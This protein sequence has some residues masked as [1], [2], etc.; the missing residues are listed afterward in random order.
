MRLASAFSRAAAALALAGS[1]APAVTLYVPGDFPAIQPALNAAAQGDTVL[2]AAGTYTGSGNTDLQIA[3]SLVLRGADGSAETLI[4]CAG[5]GRG[6]SVLPGVAAVIEGFAITGANT[7]GD[8]A[9]IRV[10]AAQARVAD[11]E[12][13]ANQTTGS[14]ARG[15]A[16]HVESGALVVDNCFI[17]DNSATANTSYGG[18]ISARKSDLTCIDTELRANQADDGG[19]IHV[20]GDYSN[21][22]LIALTRCTLAGNI[23]GSLGGGWYCSYADVVVEES[24]VEN[25]Y[26]DWTGSGM[27]L[28]SLG[29]FSL[30]NSFIDRNLSGY[31]GGGVYLSGAELAVIENSAMT[32]NAGFNG[33]GLYLSQADSLLVSNCVVLGNSA[34]SLYGAGGISIFFESSGTIRNSIIR[35]NEPAQLDIY[36]TCPVAV[37]YSDILDGWE[38]QG[39]IDADPLFVDP[40]WDYYTLRPASP[41]IDTGD[42]A[43]TD[44]CLPP[45]EGGARSDMGM[46]GGSN[47]CIDPPCELRVVA[48]D[49]PHLLLLGDLMEFDAAV[50]NRCDQALV[51]DSLAVDLPWSGEHLSIY[52]GPALELAP[53]DSLAWPVALTATAGGT[54]Q[55]SISAYRNGE[56][57]HAASVEVIV[58]AAPGPVRVPEDFPTIQE[59][60][61]A[62]FPGD[63]IW[64]APGT[65]S[66]PGNRALDFHGRAARLIGS[67]GAALTVIDCE[68][69]ER[70]F[71]FR[72][73]EDSTTSV[74][75]FTVRAG[76]ATG[77]DSP[78]DRGGGAW[79]DYA[80]PLFRDCVFRDCRAGRGGGVWLW[81][82]TGRFINCEF[83]NNWAEVGGGVAGSYSPARFQNC[84]ISDNVADGFGGGTDF[85][86]SETGVTFL[87][88]RLER[89]DAGSHGYGGAAYFYQC[90]SH[91]ADCI[92]SGNLARYAAGL[93]I[94]QQS[95]ALLERCTVS[96]NIATGGEGGGLVSSYGSTPRLVDCDLSNNRARHGGAAFIKDSSITLENCTLNANS[97]DSL[98][99]AL[100]FYRGGGR[101]LH[102]TIGYRGSRVAGDRAGRGIA[103]EV[104]RS[105]VR[106]GAPPALGGERSSTPGIMLSAPSSIR[107]CVITANQAGIAGGAIAW[108]ENTGTRVEICALRNN[109]TG[110]KGGAFYWGNESN[111]HIEGCLISDNS[112]ASGGGGYASGF[113][114]RP[115]FYQCTFTRNS[116]GDGNG[117]LGFDITPA[118][119]TVTLEN[120]ILWDDDAPELRLARGEIEVSYSDIAGGWSGPGNID[121]DPG[122]F[123]F[124]GLVDYP[125]V[126]S[127]CIDGGRPGVT[128]A[129]WDE[130]PLWPGGFPNGERADMGAYGGPLNRGWWE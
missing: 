21:K 99:G 106:G 42:P 17:H 128:D 100:R 60:I 61:D 111:A 103:N 50:V 44:A 94:F 74:E 76:D 75:G 113:Y 64:V 62:A 8:G 43:L 63:T 109:T 95:D 84:T 45:G 58:K 73:D 48:V 127:L 12:L 10:D 90:N 70:G 35:D 77:F 126:G 19:A 121:V 5:S 92:I 14:G 83:R 18:G 41:C 32:N 89:N 51:L 108:E 115:S 101:L 110:G 46:F 40:A 79:V 93:D 47:N 3:T 25:N 116:A 28:S 102:Y 114:A 125:A 6:V 37:R 29:S 123:T 78:N 52:A 33:G 71:Y 54:H 36:Y 85:Q 65:Y 27:F 55:I 34:T 7:S 56:V 119:A 130:D 117:G 20:Y 98:G 69:T 86:D 87:D 105:T 96:D 24:R 107:N 2:V 49:P 124:S 67:G 120:C 82:G 72:S 68:N 91:Y 53:D 129:V 57:V 88:C 39:N 81:H 26:S 118:L 30:H 22:P 97:A 16:I 80:A 1:S 112:A 4:D 104:R 59:G 13:Y 11:C 31:V 122:F 38:G 9:A 66:G 23:A 15:G